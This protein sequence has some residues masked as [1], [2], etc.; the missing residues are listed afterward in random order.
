MAVPTIAKQTAL[1]KL[2][3]ASMGIDAINRKRS[4]HGSSPG[5]SAPGKNPNDSS[6]NGTFQPIHPLL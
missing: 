3:F 6:E 5:K 2:I 1:F 4:I